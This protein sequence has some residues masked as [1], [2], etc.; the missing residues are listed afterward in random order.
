MYS[1]YGYPV[2]ASCTKII[3]ISLGWLA[4]ITVFNYFVPTWNKDKNNDNNDDN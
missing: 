1:F 3:V 2:D 4:F